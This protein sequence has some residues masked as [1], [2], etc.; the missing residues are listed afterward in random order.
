M[1]REGVDYL[2]QGFPTLPVKRSFQ[3]LIRGMEGE[4]YRGKISQFGKVGESLHY[5]LTTYRVQ[6]DE[7]S[8]RRRHFSD[9]SRLGDSSCASYE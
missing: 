5:L 7:A 9:K 8:K 6:S 3:Y 2:I 4:D 1:T